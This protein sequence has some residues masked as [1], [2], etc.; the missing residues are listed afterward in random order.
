MELLV[1]HSHVSR[2]QWL[3]G[4][5]RANGSHCNRFAEINDMAVLSSS[6]VQY[7]QLIKKFVLDILTSVYTELLDSKDK[8]VTRSLMN[9]VIAKRKDTWTDM[10]NRKDVRLS[11]LD[12]LPMIDRRY[13]YHKVFSEHRSASFLAKK[14]RMAWQKTG[15]SEAEQDEQEENIIE[16]DSDDS[17]RESSNGIYDSDEDD[18][19]KPFDKEDELNGQYI[20]HDIAR[21]HY[22]ESLNQELYENINV[23]DVGDGSWDDQDWD[24]QDWEDIDAEQED[25]SSAALEKEAPVEQDDTTD[26]AK[27]DK[28]EEEQDRLSDDD[29]EDEYEDLAEQRMQQL[30][31]IHEQEL[32]QH[33][34]FADAHAILSR[35]PRR[36]W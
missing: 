34:D 1:H 23:V 20:A 16:I 12:I 24:D 6:L 9:H 18:M 3:Q 5:S 11:N 10:S 36:R 28:Q 4:R 22:C 7:H 33:L 25:Q 31:L 30:D 19:L 35:Q 32:T 21:Q 2:L 15:D 14:R 17:D 26:T 13:K 27:D 8:T 29:S